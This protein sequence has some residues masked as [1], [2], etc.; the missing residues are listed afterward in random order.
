MKNAIL[1]K[2]WPLIEAYFVTKTK[3]KDPITKDD[4]YN[5]QLILI[6]MNTL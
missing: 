3:N 1:V 4:T 6:K 5:K 2:C